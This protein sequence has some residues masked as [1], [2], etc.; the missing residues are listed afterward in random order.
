[1]SR[2]PPWRLPLV[3]CVAAACGPSPPDLGVAKPAVTLDPEAALDEA[4]AVVRVEVSN[5]PLPAAALGLF[6]GSLSD[7]YVGELKNGRVPASLRARRVSAEAWL[8]AANGRAVLAPSEPLVPGEAYTVGAVGSRPLAT[9][10]VN[11]DGAAYADR[12][13]PPHEWA[14][15]GG[16]WVFC[17]GFG[18]AG[19]QGHV[20]FDPGGV[21]ATASPGADSEGALGESCVRFELDSNPGT[22]IG[23]PPP[24]FSSVALD[25]GAVDFTIEPAPTPSDC[26]PSDVSLGGACATVFDDRATVT[27]DGRPLLLAL[28]IGDRTE[29][30]AVLPDAPFV[31]R[32]LPVKSSIHVHGTATDLAGRETPFD[33]D[34][35]TAPASPHVVLNEVMANPL[36]PEPAEEWIELVNDGT[37]SID[38]G[39]A[40][41]EDLRG[42]VEVPA[43]TLAPGRFAL[44]VSEEYAPDDGRDVPPAPGTLIVRLPRLGLSNSGEAVVL[45]GPDGTLWSRFP[46]LAPPRE[47]V[48]IARRAPWALDLD[49]RSFGAHAGKGASPGWENDILAP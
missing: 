1:M 37:T 16:R 14:R 26:A 38:L 17:G 24:R 13:W 27:S 36:G 11:G 43:A 15:G 25:P 5:F 44:L 19:D 49:P 31:L 7:Y 8:D 28:R 3:L 40:T 9:L 33:A 23:I 21:G 18:P 39:G 41:V 46:P 12:V 47:G 30:D 6:E 32:G 10:H 29:L 45:R 4:P 42:T 20:S 35:A 2:L 34:F 48:S 22:G